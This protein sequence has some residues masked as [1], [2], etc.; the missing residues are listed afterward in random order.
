MNA[1]RSLT[2]ADQAAAWKGQ[3]TADAVIELM[4]EGRKPDGLKAIVDAMNAD[5]ESRWP[6]IMGGYIFRLLEAIYERELQLR[7]V[8]RVGGDEAQH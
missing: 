4:L 7:G 1:P 2:P 6:V 3:A 5:E 8:L